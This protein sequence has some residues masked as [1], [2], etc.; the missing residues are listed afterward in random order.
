MATYLMGID[1]G[2]T[3][4][5]TCI[6]DLDGNMIGTDYREYPCYYPKPGWVEQIPEDMTPS[7]FESVRAAIRDAGVPAEDIKALAI[8]TQGS[9]FGALDADDKLIRPFMGWQDARGVGYMERILNGEF[10]D[11]ARYYEI[12]G[13]PIATVPCITKYMW[14]KDNESDNF[15]KTARISHHQ[16]FFLKEFGAEDWFVNDTATAS[17]TGIFDIDKGE[18]SAEIVDAI[19]LDID[20]LPRIVKAG[21]VVG[22]IPHDVAIQTDLAEG[23]LLCVGAMDQNCS[24]MGG[25]LVEEGAAIAVIGTYGAMYVVSEESRRD[26][27]RTLIFK[28]NS[29]PEN[30]TVEAASIASA[31]CYRWFRDTICPLEVAMAKEFGALGNAYHLINR[32]IESVPAGSNGLLFLPYLQG[33]SSGPRADPYARGGFLGI[34]L[35]TTKAEMARAV[36]EGITLEMRDNVESIRKMGIPVEGIRVVGGA[37]NSSTWNQMQADMYKVP[38]SVLEVSETGCLGA[39]LYAGIGLG[40][41]SSLNEAVDRAVRIK[42]VFEPNPDNYAAYDEAY[43]RFVSGYESLAGGGFFRLLDRQQNK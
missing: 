31:S 34:T 9:V 37:T 12:S 19:G 6:F 42:A 3:G 4:C 16:D 40:A 25:G 10:I 22:R 26:P 14:F 23:T 13:Y 11:P 15:A 2:T 38:V 41:Y 28:N 24:T 17:R 5:K 7:L 33:A 39:A 20:K 8:S 18:W 21:E 36:M 35:G 32:Q 30:F 27:N 43:E 29:G 1:A